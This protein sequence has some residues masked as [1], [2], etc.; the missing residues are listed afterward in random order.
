VALIILAHAGERG[1]QAVSYTTPWDTF[2]AKHLSK[3][4]GPK[5]RPSCGKLGSIGMAR[6]SQKR[7]NDHRKTSARFL[8]LAERLSGARIRRAAVIFCIVVWGVILLIVPL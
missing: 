1:D 2:M 8:R 4:F 5:L 3:R 6:R 7:D